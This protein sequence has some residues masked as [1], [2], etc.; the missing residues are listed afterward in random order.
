MTKD[1]NTHEQK[2]VLSL[3]I[4]FFFTI[5]ENSEKVEKNVKNSKCIQLK[6]IKD[7]K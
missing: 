1:E 7:R 5:D 6:T 2:T 4:L 3:L